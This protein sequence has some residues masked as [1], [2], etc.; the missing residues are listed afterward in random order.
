MGLVDLRAERDRREAEAWDRFVVAQSRAYETLRYEDGREAA[1]AWRAFVEAG[2][3]ADQ[4][5]W[6]GGNVTSFERRR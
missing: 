6:L 1:R 2:M 4:V 3:T 5:R